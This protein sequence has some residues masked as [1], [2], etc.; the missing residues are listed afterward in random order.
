MK[1]LLRQSK[2]TKAGDQLQ[3]AAARMAEWITSNDR[4]VVAPYEVHMA[5]LEAQDAVG[6]WTIARQKS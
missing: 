5:A 3:S 2:L 1:A 4:G 6:E